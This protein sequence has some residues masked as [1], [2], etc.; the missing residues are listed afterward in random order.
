MATALL[1]PLIPINKETTREG[2][3][4]ARNGFLGGSDAS[5]ILGLNPYKTNVEVWQE[6]NRKGCSRGHWAQVL[7]Q[8]WG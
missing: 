2:W 1:L 3:L 6:K 4:Q 5:A 7:C 8:I